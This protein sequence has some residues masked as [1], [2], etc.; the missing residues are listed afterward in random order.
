MVPLGCKQGRGLLPHVLAAALPLAL[1][2][3]AALKHGPKNLEHATG[4]ATAL[5]PPPP[6]TPHAFAATPARIEPKAASVEVE[7]W[8][9]GELVTIQLDPEKSAVEFAE[10]LY[11]QVC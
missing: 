7:D 6:L 8:D 9:S 4:H 11:K 3:A 5:P 2:G 1:S 10:G